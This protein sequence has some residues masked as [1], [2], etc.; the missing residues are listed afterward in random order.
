MMG[1]NFPHT[2]SLVAH[3]CLFRAESYDVIGRFS[4]RATPIKSYYLFTFELCELRNG[5]IIFGIF[6]CARAVPCYILAIP[7]MAT[8]A[9]AI[10]S[11]VSHHPFST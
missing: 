7:F 11:V 1:D 5:A 2:H 10:L 9:S 3:V 8:L 4:H 6:P